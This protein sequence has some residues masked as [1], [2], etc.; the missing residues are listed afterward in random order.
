M[1]CRFGFHLSIEAGDLFAKLPDMA[2][3]ELL[4]T[5]PR[6]CTTVKQRNFRYPYATDVV[7]ARPAGH[8]VRHLRLVH[9]VALRDQT[10]QSRACL[11]E[12]LR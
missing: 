4:G 3:Q 1:L 12:L 10:R 6:G 7:V 9:A 11:I 8:F 2:L 5:A